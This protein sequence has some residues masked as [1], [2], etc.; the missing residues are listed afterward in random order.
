MMTMI[1]NTP[2]CLF[3]P[4]ME[5]FPRLSTVNFTDKLVLA[6]AAPKIPD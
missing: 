5:V 4:Y 3:L 1:E 6:P 2:V